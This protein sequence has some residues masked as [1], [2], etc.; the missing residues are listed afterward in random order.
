M[1]WIQILPDFLGYQ[2][3]CYEPKR[4]YYLLGKRMALMLE[5]REVL[6]S[7]GRNHQLHIDRV[8]QIQFQSKL[9]EVML[10][11]LPLI[12]QAPDHG[13]THIPYSAYLLEQ[14]KHHLDSHYRQ[15]LS[16]PELGKIFHYSPSH[17]NMLFRK[18]YHMPILKY[19]LYKRIDLAEKMLQTTSLEVKQV[20]YQT[21]FN[22][23]LYFSRMFR[24]I[25][26]RSPS[27]YRK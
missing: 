10:E 21:G 3:S 13:V 19:I 18:Q 24:K 15:P 4:G 20:A 6:L 5:S 14:V 25:K 22:D 9:M 1:F 8:L 17:L 23:P 2:I 7:L 11:S 12:R 26:G 27:E 16:L